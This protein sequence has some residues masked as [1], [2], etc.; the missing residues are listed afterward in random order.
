LRQPMASRRKEMPS[1]HECSSLIS[2]THL[3]LF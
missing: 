2:F 3:N 1:V